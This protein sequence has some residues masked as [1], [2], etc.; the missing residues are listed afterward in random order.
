MREDLLG[1]AVWS[2]GLE[3]CVTDVLLRISRNQRSWLACLNPH[4]YV[5]AR[6]RPDFRA[7]LKAAGWLV[8]D[9][10]GVVLASR[11]LGGRIRARVTGS[12]AFLGICSALNRRG[13]SSIFF[14]G[15][16]EGTLGAIQGRAARDWPHIRVAGVYS[17]PFR[18]AFTSRDNLAMAAAI[19]EARPE[20]LWVGLT[21]PKQEEWIHAMLPHLDVRF[22]GAIG[23]AFDFYAGRVRRPGPALQR[24]GLEWLSRLLREP[25]RLWR[26]TLVS[27][28]IFLRDV[29]RERLLGTGSARRGACRLEP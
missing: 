27:A 2:S 22:V 29:L 9:G 17:P 8:P 7:A 10:I 19:N 6:R 5:E 28:P 15:S 14:L 12:D 25:R 1:Y 20:V 13:G 21:A 3:A 16:T 4:S 26:R 23:A 24:A 18:T 11:I